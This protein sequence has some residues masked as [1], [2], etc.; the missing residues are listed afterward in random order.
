MS[1]STDLVY[2]HLTDWVGYEKLIDIITAYNLHHLEGDFVEIGTLFGGGARKL[3]A[4]L[5]EC[6]PQKLLYVIDIFDPNTDITKNT[7][8]YPMNELYIRALSTLGFPSQWE[9]FQRV[10]QGCKNIRVLKD[11]SK[12]VSLP[13]EKVAFAFIDGN[14]APDYVLND[15]HLVW[16]KLEPGGCIAFDDYRGNLPQVTETI[17]HIIGILHDILTGH[18]YPE[19]NIGF[20]LKKALP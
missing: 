7:D 5:E 19:G 2:H 17:D 16:D 6:A 8:D 9:V 4:F 14:H 11:D 20:L 15:F 1:D 3:S 18:A 10:T 13:T 12:K